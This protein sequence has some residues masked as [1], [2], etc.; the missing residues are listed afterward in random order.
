[1]TYLVKTVQGRTLEIEATSFNLSE[2]G[3]YVFWD[4]GETIGSVPAIGILAVVKKASAKDDGWDEK[5]LENLF[6]SQPFFDHVMGLVD[7]WHEPD[8]DE[9]N[10]PKETIN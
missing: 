4:N 1:M 6:C 7:F 3:A 10:E 8:E 9:N 2:Q 5:V